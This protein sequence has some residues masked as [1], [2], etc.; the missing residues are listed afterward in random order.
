[1]AAWG[2]QRLSDGRF[3]LGLGTQVRA[4]L[5]RRFGLDDHAIGPWMRDY[6]GAVRAIWETWQAGNKLAEEAG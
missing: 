6:V 2:L 1:M 4:H 5:I 3:I